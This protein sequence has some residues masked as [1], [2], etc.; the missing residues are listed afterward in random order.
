MQKQYRRMLGVLIIVLTLWHASYGVM[1]FFLSPSGLPA[2]YKGT[3][4]GTVVSLPAIAHGK[5]RFAVMTHWGKVRLSWYGP[6][7]RV[8]P[9]D[10]WHW[11]VKLRSAYQPI[12]IQHF[13]YDRWLRAYGFVATGYIINTPRNHVIHHHAWDTPLSS[14]RYWLQ[15]RL[16][17]HNAQRSQVG[18]LI[19]LA[20]GDRGGLTKQDW[21][22][23]QH[24]GTSHLVA[25]SGLHIGLV[26]GL[27]YWLFRAVTVLMLPLLKRI[28]AQHIAW[29][30]AWCMALLYSA[31]AGF[32]IS[33]E[34]ALIMLSVLAWVRITRQPIRPFTAWLVALGC[35]LLWQPASIFLAGAWLSFAAVGVLIYGLSGRVGRLPRWQTW[36]APQWVVFIGLLP[37]T[38]FWFQKASWVSLLANL[39]AIPVVS[40]LVVP[41]DLLGVVSVLINH[42]VATGCF[43]LANLVMQWIWVYLQWLAH[44][45]WWGI[46]HI[47]ITPW[48]C[49]VATLAALC[50]LAP[51]ALPG[52]LLGWLVVFSLLFTQ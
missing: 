44:W 49:T 16:Y 28:P 33:T 52:R 31:L 11:Q 30:G 37:L 24:T 36:L 43:F 46:D 21:Q 2:V 13:R 45:R 20:L 29:M 41:L 8:Q 5:Q 9:G 22:I 18:I 14:M 17:F 42:A 25:I 51:Q 10:Q 48:Q 7:H 34:R 1:T 15:K 4:T 39:V 6:Y 27:A 32:A 26:A 47:V 12:R 23:L 38:L 35:V 3:L 40:L 50:T 19:A